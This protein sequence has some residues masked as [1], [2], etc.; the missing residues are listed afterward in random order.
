MRF[1]VALAATSPPRKTRPLLHP[2]GAF[3][4]VGSRRST[5]SGRRGRVKSA[6][7]LDGDLLPSTVEK[8]LREGY[9]Y[10]P[11]EKPNK[12]ATSFHE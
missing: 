3:S 5:K 10:C 4:A 1:R 7:V 12:Y 9:L 2:S 8:P 6:P 11:P